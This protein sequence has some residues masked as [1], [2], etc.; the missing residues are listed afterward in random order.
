MYETLNI[1]NSV[2]DLFGAGRTAGN[3]HIDGDDVIYTL[4]NRI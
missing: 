2:E 1:E 3:I 4:E